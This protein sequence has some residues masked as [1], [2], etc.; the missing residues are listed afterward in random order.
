MGTPN[1]QIVRYGKNPN[2]SLNGAGALKSR[3]VVIPGLKEASAERHVFLQSKSTHIVFL[4]LNTELAVLISSS[5]G[6]FFL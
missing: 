5:G 3:A 2:D 4:R 6:V 1:V